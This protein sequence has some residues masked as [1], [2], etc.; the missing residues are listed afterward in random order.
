MIATCPEQE[1]LRRYANGMVTEQQADEVT[2]HL[3][4]CQSCQSWL[5][6]AKDLDDTLVGRLRHST[7]DE[8]FEME[9]QCQSAMA[10]ALGALAAAS[11]A[12]AEDEIDLPSSIGDYEIVRSIGRGGMGNVY[13]AQ[14]TKLDRTVAVK[15]LASHRLSDPRMHDRFEKE[16]RAIGSLSHPNIVTAHDARDVDGLAL[17]VTEW[18]DGLDLK[19]I[20]ARTGPLSVA[21]ACEIGARIAAALS[22]IAAQSLVHRDLKP[23][24]VMINR[25]GEVKL[26]DLGLARLRASDAEQ[27]VSAATAT[28]Q[29]M[30]TADYVAPEQINDARE[31][32]IRADIYGLGCTL[33][34]LLSGNAP[35]EGDRYTTTFAKLTAHVSEQPVSLRVVA[36]HVPASVAKLI[37]QMLAK[38]PNDRP[39]SPDKIVS[40]LQE[41]ASGADLKSLVQTALVTEPS[42]SV[43]QSLAPTTATT[44]QTFWKRRVPIAVAIASGLGGLILGW[45]AGVII[46]IIHPDGSKT[47]IDTPTESSVVIHD[48]GDVDVALA[49]TPV[50]D[51][52]VKPSDP[53]VDLS[54]L[55]RPDDTSR[56][57]GVW[58]ADSAMNRGLGAP[59]GNVEGVAIIFHKNDFVM[60]RR[61]LPLM[62]AK[63][64]LDSDLNRITLTVFRQ[65]NQPL[66]THRAIYRFQRDD[67]LELCMSQANKDFPETFDHVGGTNISTVTFS[68]IDF[69]SDPTAIAKLMQDPVGQ[70]LLHSIAMYQRLKSKGTNIAALTEAMRQSSIAREENQSRNN[71]KFMALAFHNYHATYNAF[72]TSK[73]APMNR[74]LSEGEYPCSWRVA[75]LPFIEQQQ[76]FEQYNFKEPWDSEQNLKLLDKMPETYRRPSDPADST[77]TG[78]V[79][80]AGENTI[81][82]VSEPKKIRDTID[83]TSNTAMLVEAA[84]QIPWT[85]PQDFS[86]DDLVSTGLLS[87]DSL[88]VALADGSVQE[89]KPVT[90]EWIKGVAII[91]DGKYFKDIPA[92]A[93]RR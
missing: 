66:E 1:L 63:M 58:R 76:L 39:A 32:D 13:L 81:L 84:T 19:D 85:K 10:I 12:A 57:E 78:Y 89:M 36:P 69:D 64:K 47:K 65:G 9:P 21:N 44:T 20:L 62:V 68:R 74:E 67:D 46:T 79:G 90:A 61:S 91:N 38:S 80:F 7:V 5:A 51:A 82:G 48:N 35:F 56:F 30:G 72:P 92:T 59:I 88:L 41:H 54:Q 28:G 87:K 16:M 42:P 40:E 27:E 6:D 45:L 14:H 25:E 71:L 33:Y 31:V 70:D 4:E 34:K 73:G 93:T 55:T 53:R 75:L 15:V 23:S 18:I 11:Q 26:L 52:A 86:L 50:D 2:S 77:M 37:D 3:R 43:R 24:N 8:S 22:Y 17:L 83:G 29:A 60:M 49:G